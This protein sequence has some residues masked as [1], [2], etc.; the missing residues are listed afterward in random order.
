MAGTTSSRSII[1][2]FEPSSEP[3][4]AGE[5]TEPVVFGL[6]M[7]QSVTETLLLLLIRIEACAR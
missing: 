4:D 5:I 2:N 7:A 1:P 3:Q 6:G